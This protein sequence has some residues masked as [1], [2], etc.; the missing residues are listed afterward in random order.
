LD[1]FVCAGCC[2]ELTAPV[3]RIALPVH[4]H[5]GAWEE[6]HP[7]LMESATYAVDP[8]PT[9]PPWRLWEEVG[10]EAAARQG[11]Y[12]PVYSV[13]FGARGRIVIAPGDSRSMT[14]IL[15]KCEVSATAENGPL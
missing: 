1:V 10:E 9:G 11:V 8:Q 2:T 6:L 7:P 3:S 12:A 13:S 5:H 4:T 15:E 14:L